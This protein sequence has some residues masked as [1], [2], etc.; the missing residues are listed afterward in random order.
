MS[1]RSA[2]QIVWM[3]FQYAKDDR[4]DLVDAYGGNENEQAVKN[5]LRDIRDIERLQQELFGTTESALQQSI[6]TARALTLGEI[7]EL[8]AEDTEEVGD[9]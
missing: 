6:R 3:A 9:E 7:R 4:R 8:V 2:R 5:A 1:K